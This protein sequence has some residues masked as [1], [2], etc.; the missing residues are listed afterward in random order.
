[1]TGKTLVAVTE[2]RSKEPSEAASG[3][4]SW[5]R[6]PAIL[7][8]AIGPAHKGEVCREQLEYLR[9]PEDVRRKKLDAVP[10]DAIRAAEER[11]AEQEEAR[12]RER[13]EAR[14]REREEARQRR[15]AE[16]KRRFVENFMRPKGA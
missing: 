1:M 5:P 12:H 2:R 15:I 7:A 13:K 14:Q 3:S 8:P 9:S 4:G 16:R 6:I 11:R 10:D